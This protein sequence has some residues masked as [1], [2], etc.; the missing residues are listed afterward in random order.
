[1]HLVKQAPYSPDL[2]QCDRW[3][4][5]VLKQG[6]REYKLASAHDVLN[7]SLEVFRKIPENRFV[8]ELE[9]LQQHCVK[10]IGANGDYVTLM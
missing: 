1:M 7:A 5:K 2:N 9:N 4:F 6:L 3:L 8:F 10:V